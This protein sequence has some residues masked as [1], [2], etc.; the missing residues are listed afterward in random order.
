MV[1]TVATQG[2][3][4][5]ARLELAGQV[6]VPLKAVIIFPPFFA[7]LAHGD[8]LAVDVKP[9][10][11]EE[12]GETEVNLADRLPGLQLE[13]G[14]VPEPAGVAVVIRMTNALRLRVKVRAKHLP[15]IR[16]SLAVNRIELGPVCLPV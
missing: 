16:V 9:A 12:A 10:F 7:L 14:A 4:V 6:H 3:G 15:L 13:V 1:L 8:F 5:F 11:I 2:D